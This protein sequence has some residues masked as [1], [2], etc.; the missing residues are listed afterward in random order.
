MY[1]PR[2]SNFLS[3][4][5]EWNSTMSSPLGQANGLHVHGRIISLERLPGEG[6]QPMVRIELDSFQ[7]RSGVSGTLEAGSIVSFFYPNYLLGRIGTGDVVWADLEFISSWPKLSIRGNRE[8]WIK[9]LSLE[10]RNYEYSLAGELFF[11][12]ESARDRTLYLDVG[13]PISLTLGQPT[14]PERPD[15]LI[16]NGLF[17]HVASG[18]LFGYLFD[19]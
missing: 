8:K 13:F 9:P 18:E 2:M 14:Y 1:N 4:L 6:G 19:D 11:H 15:G 5:S 12:P 3:T 16:R 17:V 7:Q 10:S